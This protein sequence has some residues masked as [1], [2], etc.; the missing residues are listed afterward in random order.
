MSGDLELGTAYAE[1]SVGMFRT[2]ED[3]RGLP[4]ALTT[5]ASF[6]RFGGHLESARQLYDEAVATARAHGDAAKLQPA[7]F[8][9][10]IFHS[11][12]GDHAR[13]MA[14]NEESARLARELGDVSSEL[15][16]RHNIA[17]SLRDT[18]R[19]AE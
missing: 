5:L 15:S 8:F 2:V 13:A 17:C 9:A 18:G 12:K 3:Q 19:V 10:A 16:C 14:L 1:A 11:N 4:T 6:E 7:L